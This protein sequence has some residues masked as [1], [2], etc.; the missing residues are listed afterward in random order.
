MDIR[1]ISQNI[2]LIICILRFQIPTD[3]VYI[4]IALI[5]SRKNHPKPSNHVPDENL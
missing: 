2:K 1:S 4:H 5:F 3:I